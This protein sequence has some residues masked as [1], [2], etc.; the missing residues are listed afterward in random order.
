MKILTRKKQ[1]EILKRLCA[2]EII[3][4]SYVSELGEESFYATVRESENSLEIANIVGGINGVIKVKN[5][6][7]RMVKKNDC[8]EA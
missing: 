2:N 5:T 6:V 3:R 4:A 1:D 7:E 8:S